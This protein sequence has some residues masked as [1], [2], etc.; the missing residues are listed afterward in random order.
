MTV[1]DE[2]CLQSQED[3][4]PPTQQPPAT[5]TPARQKQIARLKSAAAGLESTIQS[6]GRPVHLIQQS[7]TQK[8]RREAIEGIHKA[9]HAD[10]VRQVLIAIAEALTQNCCPDELY[11]ITAKTEVE[12]LLKREYSQAA[13]M[14]AFDGQEAVFNRALV[15]IDS[16]TLPPPLLDDRETQLLLKELEILNRGLKSFFP[17]PPSL[18]ARMVNLAH[19]KPG[20][21]VLEPEAGSGAIAQE[22]RKAE[23]T[24]AVFEIQPE[25]REILELKGFAIAG[26][27]FLAETQSHTNTYDAVIANPPFENFIDVAHLQQMVAVTKPGH[28]IVSLMSDGPFFRSDNRSQAFRDW[29]TNLNGVYEKIAR[30]TFA[31]TGVASTLV[32][33]TKPLTDSSAQIPCEFEIG[34]YVR[35]ERTPLGLEHWLGQKTTVADVNPLNPLLVDLHVPQHL[36]TNLVDQVY[37]KF[38]VTGL[39]VCTQEELEESQDSPGMEEIPDPLALLGELQAN[40]QSFNNLLQSLK[41]ELSDCFGNPQLAVGQYVVEKASDRSSEA[42][43]VW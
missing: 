6:K 13:A 11:K 19:L 15:A 26:Q 37:L 39:E 20:D 10:L 31:T 16:L 5:L 17:T 7:I 29:F 24:V 14:N 43:K 2:Q 4:Q 12:A 41:A 22:I 28:R 35:I 3:Q 23:V 27:D 38:P 33:I 25:L 36:R 21:L 40:E 34:D 32:V 1:T 18:A 8:R 42:N 9:I 30:G